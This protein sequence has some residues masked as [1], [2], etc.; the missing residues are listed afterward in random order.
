[1]SVTAPPS[2]YKKKDIRYTFSIINLI[3]VFSFKKT[4][5]VLS[6]AKRVQMWL[7]QTVAR[8]PNVVKSF[9]RDLENHKWLSLNSYSKTDHEYNPPQMINKLP[10]MHHLQAVYHKAASISDEKN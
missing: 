4:L 3:Q 5:V 9:S 7:D 2:V 6:N 8:W 1:M 10:T